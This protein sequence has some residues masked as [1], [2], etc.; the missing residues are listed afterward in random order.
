MRIQTEIR[1]IT[2]GSSYEEGDCLSLV[3]L[4]KKNGALHPVAPRKTVHELSESYDLIFVH[5]NSGYENWIGTQDSEFGGSSV[6]YNINDEPVYIFTTGREI[7]DRITCI[8]QIGNTLSLITGKSILY[9]LCLDG[10][11]RLLGELPEIPPVHFATSFPVE[12][13]VFQ[14]MKEIRVYFKDEYGSDAVGFTNFIEMT[15]GLVYKAMD[16]LMNG[17]PNSNNEDEKKG[18]GLMLFDACFVRYAF[19]L[20]DGSLVKHSPPVL[21]MPENQVVDDSITSTSLKYIYY[22]FNNSSFLNDTSFVGVHGYKIYFWSM[23]ADYI[24]YSQW[25][26]VIKSIDIFISQPLGIANIENIRKDL[27]LNKDAN[28][29]CLLDKPGEEILNGIKDN[30]TFYYIKSIGID[31][32]IYL[33]SPEVFPSEDSSIT[34]ME[35]LIYQ[36]LMTDDPFSHHR[37]A[38]KVS[39]AYNSRLHIAGIR[40]TFFGGFSPAYFIWHSNYNNS[41]NIPGT[42]NYICMEVDLH[43]G[44]GT[45]KAYSFYT[46]YLQNVPHFFSSAFLSYPD[47]RAKRIT[48]YEISDNV[49]NKIFSAPLTEH[50]YLNLAYY[51]N[52]ELLPVLAKQTVPV[53][54]PDT[55]KPVILEEGNKLK[56]SALNNPFLFPNTQTYVTGNGKI[57]NM[58]SIA[59]RI[60]EGQFGQYPLYVFTD[61]GIYSMGVGSGEAVY[62][63]QSA[64]TSYEIPSTPIVCSTPFGVVFTSVRGLCIIRGQEVE[65]LSGQLQQDAQDLN[66]FH[67]NKESKAIGP[68]LK[69]H[70]QKSFTRYLEDLKH[71]AYNPYENEIIV[72]DSSGIN[73]VLNLYG[74]S[75]YLSTEKI[76]L[77]VQNTFP[78]LYV[79]EGDKVKHYG[80]SGQG[81]VHVSFITRPLLFATPDFKRLER[82]ILRAG[83]FNIQNPVGGRSS[84]VLN[85]C[86]ID[87]IL[88]RILRGLPVPVKDKSGKDCKDQKDMDMGLFSRSTY[89]QFL[90]AFCGR[91][92]EKSQIHYIETEIEKIF[93]H[94]K[95]R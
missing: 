53:T 67:S 81:D 70:I 71:I 48:I 54:K 24:N 6:Y 77:I 88:F 57:L 58:A 10:K 32:D 86:S 62:S 51:L 94:T 35:N 21:V 3:N 50:R 63:A 42:V 64:P 44:A 9:L 22:S 43:T 5:Q 89:R 61:K 74:Q 45:G 2:T 87:G 75:F 25:K 69:Q 46:N 79:S 13:T 73:Y 49:W 66:L 52:D 8:Q 19:R 72:S 65:L 59:T 41:I 29:Y 91:I 17:N 7:K 76:D 92:D 26:D 14:K 34:K 30:S 31:K 84:F 20:Y 28:Y 38:A 12:F 56:V 40:T 1:G 90:F 83:L 55:S 80:E 39:Y 47:R 82:M 15:K 93:G 68:F 37:Q 78:R 85:Y 18:Y 95:M 60:S 16:M 4:R 36:E 23:I 27:A 11:Y 33:S